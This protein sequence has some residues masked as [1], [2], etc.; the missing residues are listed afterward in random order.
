MVWADFTRNRAALLAVLDGMSEA[1]LAQ[2]YP[3][4][5]SSHDLP[6]YAWLTVVL[7]DHDLEHTHD[8]LAVLSTG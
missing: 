8:L 2:P 1:E 3:A 6:A 5:W 7:L 4:S